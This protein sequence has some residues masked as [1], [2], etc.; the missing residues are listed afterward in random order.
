MRLTRNRT[1]SR[2]C[3]GRL[4]RSDR[5]VAWTPDLGGMAPVEPV[6]RQICAR[7]AKVFADFG[8]YVEDA[9]PDYT[10][11]HELFAVLNANLLFDA[12]LTMALANAKRGHRN[13]F[14]ACNVEPTMP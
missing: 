14:Y 11:A 5:R 1:S 9:S 10:G 6:V 13:E 3:G 8:C 7:A 4:P 2:G 12:T